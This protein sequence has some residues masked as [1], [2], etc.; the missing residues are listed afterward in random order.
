MA[1]AVGCG[2]GGVGDGGFNACLACFHALTLL[3]LL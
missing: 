1:E 3:S 2:D